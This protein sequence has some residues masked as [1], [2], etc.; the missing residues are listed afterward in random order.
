MRNDFPELL[1]GFFLRWMDAGRQL[2]AQTIA[3][4]RDAFALLLRWFRDE[5]GTPAS[6]VSMDDITA[7]NVEAFLLYLSE[8]RGNSAQTV[9]CRLAAIKAFCSYAAYR[10]PERLAE[11]RRVS[12]IPRRREKR[13]EV[14]YLTREEVGW[15]LDA[16]DASSR[17]G[18]ED[19]LLISVL[20]ST[21]ARISEATGLRMRSFEARDGGLVLRVVGKGRK[22]RTLP[23]WPEV[24]SEL[25]GFAEERSLGPDDF[26]FAGR[27]VEHMTRS[28]A[29]Y[30]IDAVV[31]RAA[32]SHPS[33]AD[34]RITA[35]VFRHS[36]AMS[37]LESGVDLSTIAIWLGHE[38]V[39]TTHRYMVADI[40][41]KTD[42]LSKVHPGS[43]SE[44]A[45]RR[46][47][48]SGDVL[49]FLESL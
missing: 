21:G 19:H 18:R 23:V 28:G 49:D 37:M 13:R 12:D 42:A 34:K 16:C 38:S 44:V 41:R 9:N 17:A 4:Y 3:S 2:S 15:L 40:A 7:E 35:H 32:A 29:R 39:Q 1:E 48:A 43:D 14:D 26:V 5:R 25:R 11:L 30:R 46:Y 33:L 8:R 31:R 10:A 6:E 36:C 24:A 47:R 27:N 45:P 22:E 20:F